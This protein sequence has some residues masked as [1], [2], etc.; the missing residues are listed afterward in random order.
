MH[1]EGAEIKNKE[2][3]HKQFY[4]VMGFPGYY[5]HNW[6]AWIDCMSCIDYHEG[7]MTHILIDPDET[8]EIIVRD[9]EK[10]RKACPDLIKDLEECTAFVNERAEDGRPDYLKITYR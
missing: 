9:S 3:L 10:L 5:G 2:D 1:I 8:L 4:E 6:D 7:P